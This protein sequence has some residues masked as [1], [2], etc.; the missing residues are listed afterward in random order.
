MS[1]RN[2]L[3]EYAQSRE[4][5]RIKE[6][7]NDA[8]QR[9]DNGPAYHWTDN[10][11]DERYSY[12]DV[13]EIARALVEDGENAEYLR[14]IAELIGDLYAR[15]EVE[16]GLRTQEVEAEL[17]RKPSEEDSL[18]AEIKAALE[19]DS[20]DAEHEALVSVALH[21]DIDYDPPEEA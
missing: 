2:R 4:D 1:N 13:M 17:L 9:R 18:R 19:G 15:H 16:L 21:L 12:E 7:V 20:N 14:G 11:P 5:E 8:N 3:I 10:D 6:I